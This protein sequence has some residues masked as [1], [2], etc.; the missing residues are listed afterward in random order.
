M[1]KV[2]NLKELNQLEKSSI[3]K[4]ISNLDSNIMRVYGGCEN[5]NEK[6]Y[7]FLSLNE[8]NPKGNFIRIFK[9]LPNDIHFFKDGT[10]LINPFDEETYHSY[11]KKFKRYLAQIPEEIKN[12]YKVKFN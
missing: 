11:E 7:L 3:V 8:A 10:L 6:S 4:A 12:L 5:K 1:E 9:V 2:N